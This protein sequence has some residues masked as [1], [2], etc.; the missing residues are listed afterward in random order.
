MNRKHSILTAEQIESKFSIYRTFLAIAIALIFAFLLIL[1]VS[2]NPFMDF[3][4]LLIGP[5]SRSSRLITVI[6]KMI[7]LLF[8]GVAV[9]FIYSAGQI[10][11]AA[12]GAFFA[13]CV[14]STTVSL[15]P[16]IPGPIH[17]LLC[18]ISGALAGAVVMGIP[19]IL[20]VKYDIV[21][22]VSSLMMNYV[23]LYLG[24]Y[25]IL[26]PL[27]DPNAGFE[28]SFLFQESAI[29]PKLFNQSRIHMG[30]VLGILVVII[31]TVVLY[32]KPFGYCVRTVGHNPKFAKYSGIN[33]DRT[34]IMTSIFAGMIAGMGGVTETL[35]NY[36]RFMYSGFTNHGW[37]GIMIAVLCRNNPKLVPIGAL[38]ISYL[39]TSADALNM[40]SNI[41]PEIINV[42]Q[43]IVIIFI[44]AERFLS[45]L[46]HK[47]VI[48][49]TKKT[50]QIEGDVK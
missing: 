32:Y 29:L 34:I 48:E 18:I 5:L 16:G 12:E 22:I 19:G 47:S 39:K 35:G 24:L 44:A 20:F 1:T 49:N 36:S 41:P 2:K 30:L 9:S 23:A 40:T 21:T 28:A 14:A 3:V 17:I 25:I 13:G 31:T 38:F 7:P 46:E 10:N 11:I 42:I 27:R 33:V 4:T 26:N 45:G 15:I 6:S 43:A 50:L 8:T 37:D